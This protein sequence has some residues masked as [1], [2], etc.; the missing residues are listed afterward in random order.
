M[1]APLTARQLVRLEIAAICGN[2]RNLT[3]AER[4]VLFQILET[5]AIRSKFPTLN[6][7]DLWTVADA[8]LAEHPRPGERA[9]R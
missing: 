4:D 8:Y 7:V 6:V 3:D 2:R 9:V 1:V 5:P